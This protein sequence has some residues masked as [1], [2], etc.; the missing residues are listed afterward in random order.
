MDF[1]PK[2]ERGGSVFSTGCAEGGCT[3]NINTQQGGH[4]HG[5]SAVSLSLSL[6]HQGRV[7]TSIGAL[8][9]AKIDKY[10]CG[11]VKISSSTDIVE[12]TDL[13]HSF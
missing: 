1:S 10:S 8:L 3:L 13:S 4:S 11:G 12:T 2:Y 9:V 7:L 5:H 6:Y